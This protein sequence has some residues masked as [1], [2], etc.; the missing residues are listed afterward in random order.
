MEREKTSAQ[1]RDIG[2]DIG[3]IGHPVRRLGNI[4]VFCDGNG[5]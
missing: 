2:P 4:E 5:W 3:N 1:Y